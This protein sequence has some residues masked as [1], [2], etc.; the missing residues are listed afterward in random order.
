M[1][2]Q[3]GKR[4]LVT[5]MIVCAV[6][7]LVFMPSL[8]CA[9]AKP[10]AQK[11]YDIKIYTFTTGSWAYVMGVALA[12]MINKDSKWLRATA[13]E[14]SVPGVNLKM[15]AARP[16]LRKNTLVHGNVTALFDAKNSQDV[17]KGMAPVRSLRSVALIGAAAWFFATCDPKV[18]SL[19]D[20]SGKRVAAG[21]RDVTTLELPKTLLELAGAQ[22]VRISNTQAILKDGP[23]W[24]RDGVVDAAVATGFPIDEKG[25]KCVPTPGLFELKEV[26]DT[27]FISFE[28]TLFDSAMKKFPGY[29]LRFATLK[30]G[31]ISAKQ[32]NAV[33][34][35]VAYPVWM[36]DMEMPEEVV[37]EIIRV[38]A[39]NVNRFKEYNPLGQLITPTTMG[40]LGAEED[41]H[42]AVLKFF[43][44]KGIKTGWFTF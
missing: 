26:K 1:V 23:D 40:L 2:T 29:P 5:G 16:E 38:Y 32:T 39:Q 22:N 9:Q 28:Q 11:P 8:L 17:F 31:A 7:A 6:V 44:E 24:L 35:W 15:L 41:Y 19:K 18:K 43:K 27:Y 13:V 4:P 36:C 3:P 21:P 42:P 14:G 30:P 37:Y 12:E 33:N 20:L 34:T 25:S 10:T